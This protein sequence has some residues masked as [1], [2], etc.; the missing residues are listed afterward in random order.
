MCYK[1]CFKRENAKND[2]RHKNSVFEK[3]TIITIS[4]NI[5]FNWLKLKDAPK[6][7]EHVK[8]DV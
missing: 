6:K 5:I 8:F 4:I 3:I 2:E 1:V 7:K